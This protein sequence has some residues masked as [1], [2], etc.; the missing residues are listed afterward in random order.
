[1][2]K[3]K[4]PKWKLGNKVRDI[5]VYNKE[6]KIAFLVSIILANV[7]VLVASI[8]YM[9]VMREWYYI[10]IGICV[11]LG[12]GVFS[13]FAF[14]RSNIGRH[15]A[16]YD[17][18]IVLE[19]LWMNRYIKYENIETIEKVNNTL[20]ILEHRVGYIKTKVEYVSEDLDALRVEILKLVN[21]HK[22]KITK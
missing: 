18:C 16:I 1:M 8:Y 2:K 21:E 17:N 7:L 14:R 19:S 20:E 10:L 5:E 4:K 13:Y 9:I 15:Y 3:E 6:N 12:L 22:T 11:I